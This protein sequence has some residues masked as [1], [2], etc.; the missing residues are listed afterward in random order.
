MC[1]VLSLGV[2][3][4]I[5]VAKSTDRYAMV[6]LCLAVSYTGKLIATGTYGVRVVHNIVVFIV[7]KNAS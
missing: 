4:A 2:D 7:V 1:A 6:F 5:S 3:A